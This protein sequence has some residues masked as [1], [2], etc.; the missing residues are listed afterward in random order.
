MLGAGQL[1]EPLR[2]SWDQL[3]NGSLD[4]QYVELKGVVIATNWDTA[5]LLTPD[6]VIRITPILGGRPSAGLARYLNEMVV[7]RGVLFAQWNWVTRQVIPGEIRICDPVVTVQ[8]AAEKDAVFRSPTH[9]F[10][11]VAVRFPVQLVSTGLHG[12][13]VDLLKRE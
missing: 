12:R 13:S 9:P 11:I 3:F 5:S 4:A 1:P 6:G 8:R 7:L 10:R 2:P